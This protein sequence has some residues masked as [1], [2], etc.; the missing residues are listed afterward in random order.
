METTVTYKNFNSQRKFGIELEIGC[1][2]S[3]V[4]IQ[5]AIREISR[6][7]A[8]VTRYQPSIDN[9]YWHI[10]SDATCG[11]KGRLG[12]KGVEIASFVGSGNPDLQH[13]C[14]VSQSL[15]KIGCKV[16]DNCG[17]HIHADAADLTTNHVGTLLGYWIKIEKCLQFA[18]PDRRRSNE[19][20]RMVSD[21]YIIPKYV[22][23]LDYVNS[24]SSN[25]KGSN[26]YCLMSPTN[27]G[28]YEN[29]DRRQNFNLVNYARAMNYFQ[30]GRTTLELRW[31]EG[32]LVPGDIA[33]WTRLFLGFIE[34][35]KDRPFPENIQQTSLIDVLDCCGLWHSQK[36]FTIFGKESFETRIWL[37]ERFAKY[38][39]QYT[40][41]AK[42]LLDFICSPGKKS[43]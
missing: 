26:L 30:S 16:N 1:T 14:D 9:G 33:G 31:P 40:N 7:P 32:T 3:K 23:V 37:L 2:V 5:S 29:S 12:P 36:G 20:C 42:E 27:T 22:G 38:E 6:K 41:E 8:V 17:L 39:S 43:A 13:I 11:P 19:Y 28:Y 4:K 18:L 35:C 15:S 10:K 24:S 21:R 25:N 34:T